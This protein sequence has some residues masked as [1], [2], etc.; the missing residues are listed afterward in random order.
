MDPTFFSY[1]LDEP[2]MVES[3][4]Q[5]LV[6]MLNPA[7]LHPLPPDFFVGAVQGYLKDGVY[8]SDHLAWHPFSS[9]TVILHLGE[10]KKKMRAL[11]QKG[12][13]LIGA[14]TRDDFVS[15]CGYDRPNPFAQE[16]GWFSDETDSFGGDPS[17]QD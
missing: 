17:G 6:V 4:G 1:N 9:K 7:C 13:I 10:A 2:P 5:G 3:W 8:L 14:I 11:R 15:A 12:R 16:Q